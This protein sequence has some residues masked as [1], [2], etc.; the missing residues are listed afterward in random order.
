MILTESLMTDVPN[1]PAESTGEAARRWEENA[2]FWVTIIR[3]HRDRYRTELTDPAMYEAIG[4]CGGSVV[5]DAGCGEGYLA[6][7][8]RRLGA[9]E[10]VGVDRSGALIDAAAAAAGPDEGLSFKTADLADIPLDDGAFDLVVANHVLNDLSDITAPI[11]EFARVLR[12]GGRLVALMLHPCFY[13]MRAERQTLRWTLPAEEYFSSRA[14]EQHFEVDGIVSPARA[15]TRLRP[16]EVYTAA[17]AGAGFCI[18]ALREPHPS[19]EQ[20]HEDPWWASNFPRPLFLL[21]TA[22]KH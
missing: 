5:L 4:D 14:I 13:G 10:V 2:A 6:R 17:L 19:V 21:L 20:L 9:G 11:R 3:E 15:I 7:E 18:T 12:P 16:L 22:A 8:I 1:P